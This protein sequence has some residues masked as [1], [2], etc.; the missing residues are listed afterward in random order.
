M[1][2]A[3]YAYTYSP[4]ARTLM[5]PIDGSPCRT[6]T[7]YILCTTGIHNVV[8][9]TRWVIFIISLVSTAVLTDVILYSDLFA[10]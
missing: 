1:T 6:Y 8:S 5:A 9:R 7:S 3:Y 4:G 2:N 10:L